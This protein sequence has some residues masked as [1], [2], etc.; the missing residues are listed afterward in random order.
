MKRLALLGSSLASA[1]ALTCNPLDHGAIGDGKAYDTS[2]VRS[3]VDECGAAGGGTVEFPAGYKFLTVSAMS[4]GRDSA[5]RD[6]PPARPA[7]SV[8]RVEQY[9][10]SSRR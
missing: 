5:R 2:A 4:H 9:P 8:Q 10:A 7:G 3:A 1:S 6:A